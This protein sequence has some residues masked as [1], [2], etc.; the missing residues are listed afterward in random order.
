MIVV[1]LHT[2]AALHIPLLFPPFPRCIFHYLAFS[3]MSHAD[4]K[5]H[6]NIRAL[7]WLFYS[8]GQQNYICK[9]LPIMYTMMKNRRRNAR[10]NRMTKL[11]TL[12]GFW[13]RII[14]MKY[15]LALIEMVS[16]F[17]VVIAFHINKNFAICRI[18]NIH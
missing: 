11:Y 17:I 8:R 5:W 2:S 6:F 1:V 14:T 13:G 4:H 7:A 9:K 3:S 10:G 15:R 12:F 16:V 18:V